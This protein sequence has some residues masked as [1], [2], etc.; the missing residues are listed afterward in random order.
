MQAVTK[1]RLTH[2]HPIHTTHSDGVDT[3]VHT[4]RVQAITTPIP[5][6]PP[7][8]PNTLYTV[9]VWTHRFTPIHADRENLVLERVKAKII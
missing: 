9:M 3:Q 2:T 5:F 8:T 4:D 1:H 6:L 7:H